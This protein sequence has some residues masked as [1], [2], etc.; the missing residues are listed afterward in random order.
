MTI[1]VVGLSGPGAQMPIAGVCRIPED[2]RS[3]LMAVHTAANPR[4]ASLATMGVR[5]C[6]WILPEQSTRPAATFVPPTSTPTTRLSCIYGD[7]LRPRR[8]ALA[9]L[10]EI[11]T[12]EYYT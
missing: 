11:K 10:V 7:A 5:L 4:A 2:F 12:L 8:G 9:S 1:P 6:A 3:S